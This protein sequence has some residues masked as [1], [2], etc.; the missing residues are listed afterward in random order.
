VN[1]R[2][3]RGSPH[4]SVNWYPHEREGSA[5]NVNHNAAWNLLFL[6]DFIRGSQV[7]LVL[8]KPTTITE[9]SMRRHTIA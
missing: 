6:I 4:P 8:S 3:I 7:D 9:I 2:F 1:I 5:N